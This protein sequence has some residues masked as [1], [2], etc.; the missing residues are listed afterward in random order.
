M[1][2]LEYHYWAAYRLGGSIEQSEMDGG[3]ESIGILTFQEIKTI[4]KEDVR[5]RTG[6]DPQQLIIRNISILNR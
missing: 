2:K 6:K 4:V 5:K 3:I 1:E